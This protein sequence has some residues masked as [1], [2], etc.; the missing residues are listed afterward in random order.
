MPFGPQ[1]PAR[2]RL[3]QLLMNN[4]E[5]REWL[6]TEWQRTLEAGASNPASKIDRRDAGTVDSDPEVDRLINSKVVSIRYALVTQLLGKIAVPDRNLLVLQLAAGGDGAWDA[7][8]F[9]RAVVVP[10]V[11]DNHHVLGTSAE[12]YASKPLRRTHL[13]DGMDNVRDKTEWDALVALLGGLEGASPDELKATFRRVLASMERRL[14]AQTFAY[15]IPQRVSFPQLMDIL[16][17]FLGVPSGG[18]RPLAVA[19]A[20]F[21]ILGEGFSLFDDVQSQGVNEADA[22]GGMPGDIMCRNEGELCLVVEVKDQDLTLADARAS[23]RKAKQSGSDLTA[24][25]FAVPAVRKQDRED[26][27][28]LSHRNWA[29]GLNIYTVSIQGLS[30]HAFALLKE[31]WR[32]KFVRAIC[33][34][35]DARQDQS[36]R[37]AWHDL[38]LEQ[39]A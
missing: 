27:A 7:R 31:E 5:V 8:S 34:E 24:L 28:D 39:G 37:K 3:A 35:L 32:V 26:I 23:T 36:S 15:P 29:A 33:D 22:A 16:N 20:L 1:A 13:T 30:W 14:A 2:I 19:A 12:P 25:L 10:W 21:K 17:V 11:E 18:L 38:L 9:A 6:D 4:T